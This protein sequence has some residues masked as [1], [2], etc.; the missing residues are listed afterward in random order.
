[1]LANYNTNPYDLEASKVTFA[2]VYEK[3]SDEKYPTISKSNVN[4]Y[5]ASY[6][7]CTSLNDKLFKDLR[8]VDLQHVVDTCGRTI[9]HYES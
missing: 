8:L 3:W 4:G 2:E 1:M 7:L 5:T 6:S 9:P